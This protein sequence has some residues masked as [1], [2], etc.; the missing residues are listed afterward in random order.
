MIF[1]TTNQRLKKVLVKQK[2]LSI[3]TL[4]WHP[5]SHSSPEGDAPPPTSIPSPRKGVVRVLW[6]ARWAPR[7]Q[8]P[9]RQQLRGAPV[10]APRAGPLPATRRGA[11]HG[12]D[13]PLPLCFRRPPY[14]SERGVLWGAPLRIICG[15]Q[16][17]SGTVSAGKGPMG[18]RTREGPQPAT[19]RFRPAGAPEGPGLGGAV[20]PPDLLLERLWGGGLW[21]IIGGSGGGGGSKEQPP[22][23]AWPILAVLGGDVKICGGR[24]G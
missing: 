22:P 8:P 5:I 9:V 14:E 18:S 3:P 23:T 2:C 15:F 24:K 13:P 19:E 20:A 10:G 12:P 4:R 17:S 7:G 6:G 1:T 11:R 21:G 16:E